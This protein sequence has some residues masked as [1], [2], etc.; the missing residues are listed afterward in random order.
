MCQVNV[1]LV[2]G[3]RVVGV[4]AM[5]KAAGATHVGYEC[6]IRGL[7][8]PGQE[9]RDGG[10]NGE[11]PGQIMLAS[12]HDTTVTSQCVCACVCVPS[13]CA[14]IGSTMTW[15]IRSSAGDVT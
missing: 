12:L 5:V 10:K 8:C 13:S 2:S 4:G 11:T 6:C 1:R 14:E 7:G 9:V 3:E 15:P